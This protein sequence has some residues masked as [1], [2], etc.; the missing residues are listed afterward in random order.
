MLARA[1]VHLLLT[2]TPVIRRPRPPVAR[3]AR[4]VQLPPPADNLRRL[5]GTVWIATTRDIPGP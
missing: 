5:H 3:V 1:L 4:A 2:G